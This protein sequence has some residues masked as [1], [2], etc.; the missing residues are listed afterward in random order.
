VL[1]VQ[2][3]QLE[4]EALQEQQAQEVALALQPQA[5]EEQLASPELAPVEQSAQ[6][7]MMVVEALECCGCRRP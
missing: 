6:N 7:L 5:L 2:L 3:A 1:Q 4:Q